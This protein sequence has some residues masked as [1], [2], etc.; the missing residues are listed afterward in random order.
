MPSNRPLLPG[1]SASRADVWRHWLLR[2]VPGRVLL[3]GLAIKI[4]AAIVGFLFPSAWTVL[5]AVDA[6]GSLAL[7]FV[8]GYLLTRGVIWAQRRLLWRVRRKLI[9]S[10]VFV[11]L[12]PGIL[13]ICFFLIA[14]F[15]LF[16]N[17]SSYLLQSRV[18]TLVDQ[19]RFTAQSAVLEAE[20]GDP[21]EV[22]T[23]RLQQRQRVAATRY[24][25]TSYAIVPVDGL[26]CPGASAASGAPARPMHLGE[27][28]HLPAPERIAR[29][30]RCDGFAGLLVYDVADGESRGHHLVIRAVELPDVRQPRWAV[31]VDL[32]ISAAIEERL[33]EETGIRMG[34]I[35]VTDPIK[36]PQGAALEP[37]AAASPDESATFGPDWVTPFDIRD[38]ESGGTFTATAAIQLNPQVIYQRISTQ[39]IGLPLGQLLLVA[40]AL[41][42]V[43][44][45]TIQFVALVIGFVLARQITGAVHDLFT[46]TEHLRNRDFLYHIPVRARDQLGELAESFNLMT[47][48]IT[49]LIRENAEKARMEQEMLAAREIQQKLLP[50]GP[51]TV[52]G[53]AVTAFCEPAREVAGDYFDFLPISPTKLGVLI[54]D[55]SGKGLPAGLYMAQ[56]KVLVQSLARTHTSPREFLK[57]VNRVVADNIDSK[58]FITM[59]YGVIDLVEKEMAF[60]RAGHCPLIRV[61]GSAPAGLRKS[62]LIAPDGLVLGL[63]FDDGAMFDSM[64]DEV[65]VPLAPGDLVVFYTDGISE[66]MN[67]AFDCYGEPR[68]ARVLEQYAHLPFEQLRS[69]IFA[70]LRSFSGTADQHDDMTMILL[71]VE[72][73]VAGVQAQ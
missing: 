14:G 54:A 71:K 73:Q 45:L 7:L 50:S 34:N 61:P 5:D 44:F 48:E 66:T 68:L 38:W 59:S 11:G 24:P 16:F 57:A 56:L 19:A 15:L 2:S 10:Y 40:L 35:I 26:E 67:E 52:P 12:V 37:P 60:S 25:F 36:L 17:V 23:R 3:V 51:L 29:W 41:I 31:I 21:V 42:G 53:L 47:G 39:S 18:R 6:I 22:L 69:F 65:T 55:V 70:D 33:R 58:S 49:K 8:G 1:D 64:I 27:W 28:R 9:L 20:H 4:Q 62:E 13:I 46:G 72:G 30:I 32:P 63:K 43:L